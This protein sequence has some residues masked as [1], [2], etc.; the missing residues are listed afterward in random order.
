MHCVI[1]VSLQAEAFV[2]NNRADYFLKDIFRAAKLPVPKGIRILVNNGPL[3]VCQDSADPNDCSLIW[4]PKHSNHSS[5]S[6]VIS[7]TVVPSA[8]STSIYAN[9]TGTGVYENGA[10]MVVGLTYI[11]TSTSSVSSS[12]GT[13][14]ALSPSSVSS[15]GL[16]VVKTTQVSRP[17][18]C[19][20]QYNITA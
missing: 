1:Q 13:P 6:S 17:A 3:Y 20:A 18:P 9:P 2:Q 12:S 7:G 14:V 19:C 8:T 5:S 10:A 11:P 15:P 16:D 4:A